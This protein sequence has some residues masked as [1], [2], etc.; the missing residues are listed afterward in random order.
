MRDNPLIAENISLQGQLKLAL[1]RGRD[2][3]KYLNKN[4]LR[5]LDL[6]FKAAHIGDRPT[7]IKAI[8]C[9][10][11]RQA[12]FADGQLIRCTDHFTQAFEQGVSSVVGI[13]QQYADIIESILPALHQCH[14]QL[15][16]MN[17]AA[18]YAKSDIEMQIQR[19]F[20][21]DTLANINLQQI[22]QYPRYVR[23]IEIRLEKVPLQISKDR[24]HIEELQRFL[25]PL[26]EQL[27]NREVLG[28]DLLN[29]LDEFAWAIEE[30]RVSLFAQQLKTRVPISAKRLR[31]QWDQ[32]YEKLRRFL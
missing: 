20:S 6:A 5:G 21:P 17:L 7:L 28:K 11:F 31:K 30:Y 8:V 25:E 16:S 10:S 27:Q 29:E 4:L 24:Q 22:A 15:R 18:V 1:L 19:L 32:L 2:Q 23:A 3:V 26:E 12:I 14:R 9:A 13:A